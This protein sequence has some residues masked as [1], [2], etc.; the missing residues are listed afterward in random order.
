M[1]II[2]LHGRLPNIK[3]PGGP[4]TPYLLNYG[5]M[6]IAL[7]IRAPRNWGPRWADF[8]KVLAQGLPGVQLGEVFVDNRYRA[9]RPTLDAW[10][11]QFESGVGDGWVDSPDRSG[12]CRG[13]R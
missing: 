6:K 1:V 12:G 4:G 13:R 5:A 8:G 3:N 7:G 10:I 9:F 2:V 11:V